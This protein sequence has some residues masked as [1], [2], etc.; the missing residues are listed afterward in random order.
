ME[1]QR[2]IKKITQFLFFF[3]ITVVVLCGASTKTWEGFAILCMVGI[4]ASFGA[5][6]LINLILKSTDKKA[7]KTNPIIDL[8]PIVEPT[9]TGY[10]KKG[11]ATGLYL[12]N[13]KA[14]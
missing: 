7:I 3:L 11:E 4:P 9:H 8:E 1:E 14:V 13:K 2:N 10:N 12:E 5:T 6:F